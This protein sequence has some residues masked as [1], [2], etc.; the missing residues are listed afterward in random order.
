MLNMIANFDKNPVF[1]YEMISLVQ[2][3]GGFVKLVIKCEV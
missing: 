1:S 3:Y 2:S